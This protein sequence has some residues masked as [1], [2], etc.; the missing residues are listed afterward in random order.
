VPPL[1]D[2]TV[3]PYPQPP[4]QR[5]TGTPAPDSALSQIEAVAL[6]GPPTRDLYELAKRLRTHH[7][8]P[9]SRTVSTGPSEYRVDS[10]ETFS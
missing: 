2:A 7:E 6:E 3:T 10:K 8:A 1:P 5:I 4:I 9:L